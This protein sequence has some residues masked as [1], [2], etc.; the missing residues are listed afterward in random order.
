MTNNEMPFHLHGTDGSRYE[1]AVEQNSED[2]TPGFEVSLV[3]CLPSRMGDA[4]FQSLPLAQFET[5]SEALTHRDLVED[6]LTEQGLAGLGDAV[7]RIQRVPIQ[8]RPKTSE[9]AYYF[10]YRVGP[11]N[12]P[13]L[14]AVKTWVEPGGERRFDTFTIAQYGMFEEAQT[15]ER[16]L[17]QVKA[18]FGVERAIQLAESM[19]VSGGYLDP[20]RPDGRVFFV[21][22]APPD[23]FT[24]LRQREL[25]E[26][27][28]T[29]IDIPTLDMSQLPPLAT[30]S[31]WMG[32]D[33][34]SLLK[35]V[36]GDMNYALDLAPGDEPGTI[37]LLAQKWWVGDEGN[38]QQQS[39][40]IHT[41]DAPESGRAFS[42]FVRL[43]SLAENSGR[44]AAL[45]EATDMG[46]Q[47]GA[48]NE[49]HPMLFSQGP[50][51]AFTA[52]DWELPA[53]FPMAA[54]SHQQEQEDTAALTGSAWFEATFE[55]SQVKLLEPVHDTVNYAVVIDGVDP[56]TNELML[57]KYWRDGDHL[58]HGRAD[59]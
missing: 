28:L 37:D 23:P 10:G 56:W 20:N 58:R 55:Q 34:T 43:Y 25:S 31:Q 29:P 30:P 45:T 3:R 42:D 13:A 12:E 59:A 21:E 53:P 18:G 14:E 44:D 36:S 54:A 50:Q 46:R 33:T 38:L 8:D 5:E 16:E 2:G 51:D 4:P 17:E 27:T 32:I 1:V 24:T 35:P 9:P 39:Q 52:Y 6:T 57:M 11:N 7:E 47:N 26:V 49:W 41:Y 19:A 22:D 48:L 15:G 40:R